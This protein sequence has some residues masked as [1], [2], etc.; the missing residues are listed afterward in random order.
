M[1][2]RRQLLC[3]GSKLAAQGPTRRSDE[4]LEIWE[5]PAG[6]RTAAWEGVCRVGGSDWEDKEI[7]IT[8]MK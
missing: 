8:S 1:V 6:G 5:N 7:W 3:V 4:E 2:S